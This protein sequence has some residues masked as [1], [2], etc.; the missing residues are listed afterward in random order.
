MSNPVKKNI[1]KGDLVRPVK[2]YPNVSIHGTYLLSRDEIEAWHSNKIEETKKAIAK[3]Q[4]P[5]TINFND[6]GE[7]RLAPKCGRQQLNK[8]R[9]YEVLRARCR[10]QLGLR[11]Y[12]GMVKIL[13]TETGRELYC[14]N[15]IL[16][17]V[18]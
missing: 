13:D 3:G 2:L 5:F 6:A 11:T 8:K 7:S 12:R 17:L 10:V 16:A 15:S 1:R 14:N 4:D 18:E 9:V